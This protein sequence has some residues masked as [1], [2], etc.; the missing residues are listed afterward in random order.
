VNGTSADVTVV[1]GG[2]IGTC[3]ARELAEGGASV[4]VLGRGPELPWGCSAGDEDHRASHGVPLAN[5]SALLDVTFT[6][7]TGVLVLFALD[8]FVSR[9]GHAHVIGFWEATLASLFFV[10]VA[11]G[12]GVAV[13]LI[14]GWDLGAG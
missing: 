10:G 14:A 2:A 5:P 13:G 9:R 11:V 6:D 8:L 4:T 12:F 7:W 3:I 1:G